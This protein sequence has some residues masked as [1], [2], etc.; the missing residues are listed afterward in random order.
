MASAGPDLRWSWLSKA[1]WCECRVGTQPGFFWLRRLD[2]EGSVDGLTMVQRQ[3]GWGDSR[4]GLP[5]GL[6]LPA[7]RLTLCPLP[8]SH[9][10]T[11]TEL[12]AVPYDSFTH[13]ESDKNILGLGV[14]TLFSCLKRYIS[15]CRHNLITFPIFMK[16]FFL[17]TIFSKKNEV[18]I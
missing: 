14:F 3:H 6:C 12:P 9:H 8:H 17:N 16:L 2:C 11:D 7:P 18:T 5:M 15:I 13:E 1:A 4:D 10:P